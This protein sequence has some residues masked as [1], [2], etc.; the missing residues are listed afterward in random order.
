MPKK[1]LVFGIYEHSADKLKELL[2][3]IRKHMT[4]ARRL[5]ADIGAAHTPSPGKS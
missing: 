2:A 4:Y 1:D 5:A 3:K